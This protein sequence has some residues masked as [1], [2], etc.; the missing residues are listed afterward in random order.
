MFQALNYRPDRGLATSNDN[1]PTFFTLLEMSIS[2]P[3]IFETRYKNE[4]PLQNVQTRLIE[5]NV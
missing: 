1:E 5:A 3:I 2:L 4:I